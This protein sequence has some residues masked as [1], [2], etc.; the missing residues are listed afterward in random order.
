MTEDEARAKWCP[1]ARNRSI[2]NGSNLTVW[3][4]GPASE[5]TCACIASG[6]MAWRWTRAPEAETRMKFPH[7]DG[8]MTDPI[9]I[10]EAV[11]GEGFC[12]LAGA[13]S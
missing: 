1:F 5:P 8:G 7:K 3:V 9:K 11:P 2:E 13:P 12:G 6:C 4:M 10:K